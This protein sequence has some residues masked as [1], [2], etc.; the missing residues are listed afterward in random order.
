MNEIVAGLAVLGWIAA[1]YCLLRLREARR[2]RDAWKRIAED[3]RRESSG[4]RNEALRAMDPT[5]REDRSDA[6]RAERGTEPPEI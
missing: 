6:H 4:W 2:E 5:R 1:L 3:A